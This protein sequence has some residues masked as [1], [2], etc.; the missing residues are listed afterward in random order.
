ML[1][2][3]S[4]ETNQGPWLAAQVRKHHSPWL[5]NVARRFHAHEKQTEGSRFVEGLVTNS[6]LLSELIY[7]SLLLRYV[8]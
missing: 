8:E 5:R 6:I 3:G 2:R 1:M 4:T 7:L